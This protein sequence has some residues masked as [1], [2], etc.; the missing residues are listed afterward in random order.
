MSKTSIK[1]CCSDYKIS[2]KE[3]LPLGFEI[4]KRIYP[5]NRNLEEYK[6]TCVEDD[7]DAPFTITEI[8][9]KGQKNLFGL[10][11][12]VFECFSLPKDIFAFWWSGALD[13]TVKVDGSL[14]NFADFELYKK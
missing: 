3:A 11:R 6:N 2:K 5:N 12:G 9:L 10:Y 1:H 8:H 14:T 4:F 7:P 13:S